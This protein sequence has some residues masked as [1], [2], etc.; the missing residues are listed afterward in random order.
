MEI[1]PVGAELFH[2]DGLM[3][4][5]TKLIVAFRSFAE[6]PTGADCIYSLGPLLN[7]RMKY[8]C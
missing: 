8:E 6:V 2:T 7:M 5:R 1:R 4:C 3:D